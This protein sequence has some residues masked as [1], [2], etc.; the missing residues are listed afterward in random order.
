MLPMNDFDRTLPQPG[1]AVFSLPCCTVLMK[2]ARSMLVRLRGIACL[3]SSVAPGD[4][5][6]P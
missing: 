3:A 2:A 6:G 5:L 1:I 4:R